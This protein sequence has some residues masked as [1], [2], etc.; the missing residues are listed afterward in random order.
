MQELKSKILALE[1]KVSEQTTEVY[2]EL[3]D[4]WNQIGTLAELVRELNKE[5]S[6]LR[7]DVNKLVENSCGCRKSAQDNR[8]VNSRFFYCLIVIKGLL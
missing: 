1:L 5:V 7:T 4:I 6:E 2:K 3:S 8:D